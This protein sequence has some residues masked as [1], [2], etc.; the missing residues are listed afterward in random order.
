M[1]EKLRLLVMFD[2][3]CLSRSAKVRRTSQQFDI[4]RSIPRILY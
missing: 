1:A 4:I 3:L 2:L